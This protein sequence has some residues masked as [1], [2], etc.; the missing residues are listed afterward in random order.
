MLKLMTLDRQLIL[1]GCILLTMIGV[2][3]LNNSVFDVF[4]LCL[5]GAIGYI[6]RR[7]GYPV[8]GATIAVI[9]G[10]GLEA[11]LRGGL[12]LAGGWG[13]FLTRPWVMV[14]L[15]VAFGLLIYATI[16][17]IR[18]ARKAAATRQQALALHRER[19]SA[20]AVQ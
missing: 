20:S 2:F 1:I 11:N 6:M 5:F 3:T 16:G 14:I 8:A 7:Y 13:P 9:L 10:R 18:L 17:T 15:C 19:I 4:M 12:I